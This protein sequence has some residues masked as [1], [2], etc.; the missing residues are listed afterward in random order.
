MKE[1]YQ[2]QKDFKKQNT[3]Q[4]LAIGKAA[5]EI[6]YKKKEDEK[7]SE[8]GINELC[9]KIRPFVISIWTNLRNGF[10]YQDPLGWG[11]MLRKEF[12]VSVML[13]TVIVLINVFYLTQFS[14]SEYMRRIWSTLERERADRISSWLR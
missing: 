2:C 14:N 11:T 9:N 3:E 6:K 5:S 7:L 4:I 10:L 8:E 1:F 13:W 12:R